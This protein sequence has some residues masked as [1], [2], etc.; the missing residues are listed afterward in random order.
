MKWYIDGE[1]WLNFRLLDCIRYKFKLVKKNKL[2]I[3]ICYFFD[4]CEYRL[5]KVVNFE[6]WVI[7]FFDSGINICRYFV[8]L[9]EFSDIFEWYIWGWRG[10][11]FVGLSFL[12]V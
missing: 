9:R 7:I 2:D 10:R 6:I 5:V 8:G 1:I 12:I 11:Y 4:E 3:Y